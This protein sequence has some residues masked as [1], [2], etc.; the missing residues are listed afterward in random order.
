MDVYLPVPDTEETRFST[1][2]IFTPYYRRFKLRSGGSGE[3]SPNIAK[4]RDLFI[5]RGYALVVV[6][7]RG[8]GASFGTR[9]SFRSPREHRD[10]QEVVDWIV[11]Q[12][13]SDGRVGST[14]ISY[15]GAAADFLAATG[16][17][18]VKA[19]APLF[20]VWD[21]YSDNYY[22]GGLRIK[23]LTQTYDDLMV[24]LDH[25]QRPLLRNFS[26]YSNPDFEGPQSVDEDFDGSLVKA[27]VHEHLSNFRQTD[28]MAEFQF[29]E[30]PLP[31]DPDFSSASFSPYSKAAGVREEV[32]ILSVSG[33]RDGAGY[34]NGAIARYLTLERNPRHLLLGPW[35]HGARI[36]VSPWRQ[37]VEAD[38]P[39]LGELL[40][41]FDTYLLGRNTGL[42]D[43]DPIHYFSMH[44]QTW[45]SARSWPPSEQVQSFFLGEQASL[46]ASPPAATR[47]D[48]YRADFT[49]GTGCQTR[50]ERIAGVDCRTYYSDWTGRTSKMLNYSSPPLAGSLN[51]AGHPLVDIWISCSERDAAF[52]IYL[53]EVQD[54]GVEQYITEGL[55]R[56][57]H[58][59]EADPPENYRTNWPFRTFSRKDAQPLTPGKV[60]RIRVPLL[61]VAWSVAPNSR[62]RLSLAGADVDHFA[63]VPHGRPPIFSVFHGSDRPS[64]LL[65][66]L[67][68]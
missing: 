22:P 58:R 16:H 12:V 35:D 67:A 29:R 26:Y 20:S 13:W 50:Y 28:F 18:C 32:A 53:T 48:D 61:P 62:L 59:K 4:F 19:I 57:L 5:P 27:A 37:T 41:F 17:E 31:Y 14:G 42:L 39:L 8:T 68:G 40:R 33:W 49:I 2:V 10:S 47:Q 11:T 15:P 6:D 30:D 44:D 23:S 9:D 24:A 36:D 1:I 52:F 25:D 64:M 51:I 38:F 7:V 65:L 21:T 43:E 3:I 46:E 56:G 55:L 54:D 34:M 66:P 60:E 63:Q 45:R